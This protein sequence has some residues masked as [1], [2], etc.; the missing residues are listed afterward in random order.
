MDICPPQNS[1]N[2]VISNQKEETH[3]PNGL[4]DILV[5]YV[6]VLW[7]C[8]LL[9]NLSD[10]QAA[11]HAFKGAFLWPPK[12]V[13]QNPAAGCFSLHPQRGPTSQNKRYCTLGWRLLKMK[14]YMQPHL[15]PNFTFGQRAMTA[16]TNDELNIYNDY[17]RKGPSQTIRHQ[18]K[19]MK[20]N[21][22]FHFTTLGIL[23]PS[24]NW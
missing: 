6:G 12:K 14:W 16:L 2:T 1:C 8:T 7:R 21:E 17:Y 20:S 19:L 4:R 23:K 5:F 10:F 18:F 3:L 24:C 9:G 11:Y 13:F 22:W 15:G